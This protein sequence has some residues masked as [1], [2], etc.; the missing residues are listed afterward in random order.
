VT[1]L[2]LTTAKSK[3]PDCQRGS[4]PAEIISCSSR[5]TPGRR[6]RKS[7]SAGGAGAGGRAEGDGQPA[8]G[9]VAQLPDLILRPAQLVED[10]LGAP[11]QHRPDVRQRDAFGAAHEQGGAQALLHVAHG[12]RD[13]RLR[14]VLPRR[15][16]QAPD[17]ATARKMAICRRLKRHP[18]SSI[19]RV[20]FAI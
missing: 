9:A 2:S 16:A 8:A 6:A 13:R 3:L 17:C 18:S 15:R 20:V 7:S 1:A 10:Q 4:L 12:M 14:Q 19:T 5:D 11:H